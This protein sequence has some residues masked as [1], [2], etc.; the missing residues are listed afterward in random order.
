[1]YTNFIFFKKR[2][3][4]MKNMKYFLCLLLVV[5]LA[6]VF[7]ACGD[8]KTSDE[9]DPSTDT[10]TVV[11]V[12]LSAT[13]LALQ[14]GTTVT[15]TLTATVTVTNGAPQTVA[16][17]SSNANVATVSGG[18][19]TA[20]AQGTA[21]ITATST[22]D[23]T[24]S[25]TCVVTVSAA[26]QNTPTAPQNF[27]AEVNANGSG[28]V[29]SWTAPSSGGANITE[30]QI[31]RD[32]GENW[33]S[34][35]TSLTTTISSI[36]IIN[37]NDY[38]YKVRAVNGFG[39]G[40]E[41]TIFVQ[42][43][44]LA[45]ARVTDIHIAPAADG[46]SPTEVTVSWTAPDDVT[47]TGYEIAVAQ[48]QYGSSFYPNWTNKFTVT[49]ATTYTFE[50]NALWLGVS[51]RF[52]VRAVNSFGEGANPDYNMYTMPSFS[53]DSLDGTEW[54]TLDGTEKIA[55]TIED[56]DLISQNFI[57][58]WYTKDGDNWTE[59]SSAYVRIGDNRID[60]MT[61]LAFGDPYYGMLFDDMETLSVGLIRSGFS[62]EKVFYIAV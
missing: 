2:R 60:T 58:T 32:N 53:A 54:L 11:G 19:V 57:A 62:V 26:S 59:Y 21:T 12:T 30:Y 13:I 36:Y 45:P 6:F 5:P 50:K 3:K 44:V 56:E 18:L 37:G 4:K 41:A 31:S 40:A 42:N 14:M 16:W 25:A 52:Y 49:G 33:I 23:S 48:T 28:L 61:F 34:V 27:E 29:L 10:P 55:I 47:I 24:K 22:A 35:W 1:V 20:V 39:I 15:G 46:A 38:T 7:A 43:V 51:F 17:T 9:T 8:K